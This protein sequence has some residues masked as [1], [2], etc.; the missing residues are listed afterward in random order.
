MFGFL[1]H[2]LLVAK[3]LFVL[4]LLTLEDLVDEFSCG[5]KLLLQAHN[6]FD[7]RFVEL[8]WE[9]LTKRWHKEYVDLHLGW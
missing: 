7:I 6:N 9:V 2:P 1:D 3:Q 8:S 5:S 4:Q